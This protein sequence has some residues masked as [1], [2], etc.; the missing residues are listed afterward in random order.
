[1]MYKYN[2]IAFPEENHALAKQFS[3]CFL[4]LFGPNAFIRIRVY[5]GGSGVW[6]ELNRQIHGTPILPNTDKDFYLIGEKPE[7]REY[8]A[9]NLEG[10]GQHL[11]IQLTNAGLTVLKSIYVPGLFYT[12]K[13]KERDGLINDYTIRVNRFTPGC[14]YEVPV[15]LTGPESDSYPLVYETYYPEQPLHFELFIDKHEIKLPGLTNLAN[16]YIQKSV[17]KDPISV[18]SAATALSILAYRFKSCDKALMMKD[19]FLSF[20]TAKVIHEIL[21]EPETNYK[22]LREKLSARL[23]HYSDIYPNQEA[24]SLGLKRIAKAVSTALKLSEVQY[25]AMNR[26]LIALLNQLESCELQLTQAVTQHETQVKEIEVQTA[27]SIE[28]LRASQEAALSPFKKI[29]EEHDKVA[30]TSEVQEAIKNKLIEKMMAVFG[31]NLTVTQKKLIKALLPEN[32][33]HE[34]MDQYEQMFDKLLQLQDIQGGNSHHITLRLL[35]NNPSKT[36][37]AVRP[38]LDNL[39][40]IMK[41]LKLEVNLCGVKNASKDWATGLETTLDKIQELN[42]ALDFHDKII[43]NA[44]K[45]KNKSSSVEESLS[46]IFKQFRTVYKFSFDDAITVHK[47]ALSRTE[48]IRFEFIHQMSVLLEPSFIEKLKNKKPEQR[49]HEINLKIE[50]AVTELRVRNLFCLP[51]DAMRD[52]VVVLGNLG[53]LISTCLKIKGFA[54]EHTAVYDEMIEKVNAAILLLIPMYSVSAKITNQVSEYQRKVCLALKK[55]LGTKNLNEMVPPDQSLDEIGAFISPIEKYDAN[56]Y[57]KDLYEIILT[58]NKFSFK[59]ISDEAALQ[60]GIRTAIWNSSDICNFSLSG[61]NNLKYGDIYF[62]EVR[63]VLMTIKSI[64]RSD[65]F[66]GTN[67]GYEPFFLDRCFVLLDPSN[68]FYPKLKNSTKSMLVFSNF[69]IIKFKNFLSVNNSSVNPIKSIFPLGPDAKRV[70]AHEYIDLTLESV[71]HS[72]QVM[73]SA[74]EYTKNRYKNAMVGVNTQAVDKLDAELN[75]ELKLIIKEYEPVLANW[76]AN[77]N[78]LVKFCEMKVSQPEE[79]LARVYKKTLSSLSQN[80]NSELMAQV[81][82]ARLT[83]FVHYHL[84]DLYFSDKNQELLASI[85]GLGFLKYILGLATQDNLILQLE[86]PTTY[87]A[88]FNKARDVFFGWNVL[89]LNGQAHTNQANIY[90]IL[91][92][93]LILQVRLVKDDYRSYTVLM[94]AIDYLKD[95]LRINHV[96]YIGTEVKKL[97]DE[98]ESSPARG[99]HAKI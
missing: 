45:N 98:E 62:D 52:N 76:K 18:R 13:V 55:L 41:N 84:C 8:I 42:K 88:I 5:Q 75:Q 89:Q 67:L 31:M 57:A 1:M 3:S 59:N 86:K 54:G 82:N 66:R 2:R 70:M 77:M 12:Y 39:L 47:F 87:P 61:E 79:G 22:E 94:H 35:E 43:G 7:D 50:E 34:H 85:K 15:D 28:S 64:Y 10:I 92:S 49:S 72:P 25:Q 51:H 73:T 19:K 27:I 26:K 14:C 24:V 65:F 58:L 21:F 60:S 33:A 44:K 90:V 99:N 23:M 9:T 74:I 20:E 29:C 6:Q 40:S 81:K 71:E 97:K 69:Y 17:E 95:Q 46:S 48:T 32:L 96:E 16:E 36:L 91:C 93:L 56:E 80:K 68:V 4:R 38:A 63:N 11:G 83:L 78:E 37:A 53:Y 30:K